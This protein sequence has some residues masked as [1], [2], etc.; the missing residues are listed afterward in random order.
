MVR[1][2]LLQRWLLASLIAALAVGGNLLSECCALVE[3][4]HEGPAD[5]APACCSSHAA[6]D[7][8]TVAGASCHAFR[9]V[10]GRGHAPPTDSCGCRAHEDPCAAELGGVPAFVAGKP[11]PADGPAPPAGP[12]WRLVPG[13]SPGVEVAA[14][15]S[16]RDRPLYRLNARIRC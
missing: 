7:P 12:S 8:T 3:L 5:S 6:P 14:R 13:W 4:C 10:P 15:V 2:S 16:P 9:G 1:R 11:T